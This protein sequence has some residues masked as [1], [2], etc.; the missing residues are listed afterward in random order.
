MKNLKPLARI[1]CVPAMLFIGACSCQKD[2]AVA[3][4]PPPPPPPAAAAVPALGDVFFDFD[5]S[6]LRMDAVSQLKNNAA[7]MDANRSKRVI[8]EGHC[9]ERGTNE[10]NMALGE[11]R[12]S[13]AKEYIV[14][15]GI[16]PERIETLSYGEEKPFAQGSTEEAWAQNRR[17]HFVAE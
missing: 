4:E 6:A 8:V 9:D 3:P 5:Q 10:Y 14:S 12:A 11:R 7:W 13:S 1:L 16:S 2:V 15:L 17:A